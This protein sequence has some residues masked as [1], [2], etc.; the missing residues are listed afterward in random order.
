M[1]KIAQACGSLIIE[2]FKQH[3]EKTEEESSPQVESFMRMS[4]E[5]AFE[6]FLQNNADNWPDNEDD[7]DNLEETE[8]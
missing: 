7:P 1:F 6:F 3:F 4:P 5:K 2:S 8:D